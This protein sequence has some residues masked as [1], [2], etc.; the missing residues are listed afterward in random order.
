[1]I[2]K[3]NRAHRLAIFNHKGGVGKTTLTINIASEI[4]ALGKKVLLVDSDPQ[5][6]ITSH[7]LESEVVDDLLDTSDTPDGRTVWSALR[8]VVEGVGEARSIEPYELSRNNL[9]LIPGDIRLSEFESELGAFWGQCLQRKMRGFTGTTALSGLINTISNDL[10]FDY[11]FYDS[12]PNIGPLSRNIL[13]DCDEFIVPVACDEFSV[14]ALKT[15]GRTLAGWIQEWEIITALAPENIYL[16]PG[17]P[18]FIGYIA[19]RIRVYGGQ[20]TKQHSYYLSLIDR[21]IQSEI[22]AVLGKVDRTLSVPHSRS[23]LGEIKD[24]STLVAASQREGVAISD[25]SVGTAQQRKSAHTAFSSI[26]KKIL[27]RTS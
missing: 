12:G 18:K 11:V 16:F 21:H 8:S 3:R 26:A 13:L 14:R 2:L 5:C 24:F 1:M 19:Q 7:L 9:F 25:V 23:K 6:N 27:N 17:H 22:I 20:L 15:L 4:A 10:D